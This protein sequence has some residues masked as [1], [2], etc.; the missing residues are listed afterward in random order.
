MN[1][2]PSPA[3]SPKSCSKNY[4]LQTPKV[5]KHTHNTEATTRQTYTCKENPTHA[6]AHACAVTDIVEYT[7][8]T[9]WMHW[10]Q[11]TKI[12][13]NAQKIDAVRWT[14][15]ISN[16]TLLNT[17]TLIHFVQPHNEFIGRTEWSCPKRLLY[18]VKYWDKQL[19]PNT[20]TQTN[21]SLLSDW[22]VRPV[23]VSRTPSLRKENTKSTCLS[24]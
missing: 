8:V 6:G 18:R 2:S 16:M 24:P 15:K 10:T 20:Q 5:I 12:V 9:V 3:P 11:I 22:K 17:S 14:D 4:V 23:P 13:F 7:L 19:Q 1:C 21:N